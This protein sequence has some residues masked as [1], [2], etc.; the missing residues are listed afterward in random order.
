MAAAHAPSNIIDAGDV[1]VIGAGLAGLFTALKLAPRQVTV[2]AAGKRTSGAA[3]KWAQGGIA[4]AIG[5]D[6]S[7]ANHA[8]DT[9][10]AGAGLV[11]ADIATIL[12]HEAAERIA[13]LESFGVP[14]DRDADGQ[15]RLGREAAHSHNRIIGV[16]GDRAGREIMQALMAQAE[17][18]PSLNFIEGFAAYEL[19]VEN[20]RVV[21]VFARPASSTTLT[22]PL[23]I[24]AK[25]TILATGGSGHL[26]AVTT[27]PRFANGEA[28]A[29]A[30][31]A[32]AQISDAEFVQFHP[33]ALT[34]QGDPAPLATEALRGEGAVLVNRHG[35]RFMADVHPDAEL[36]PRDIVAR[37]VFNEIQASGGVGLDL[38]PSGLAA[39]LDTRFPTVAASCK[40]AGID[41]TQTAL[42]IAPATHFHMGGIRTDTNGRTS[43]PGLWACGEVAATGAHGANRLASN[44]LLEAIVFGARIAHDINHSVTPGSPRA[45]LPPTTHIDDEIVEAGRLVKDL[46]QLMSRHVGVVRDHA[47]LVTALHGLKRL[48][49]AAAGAAPY[50][51]MILAAQFITVGALARCESRGGHYRADH[52]QTDDTAHHSRLTLSDI[53][54][55]YAGLPERDQ[56]LPLSAH[57]PTRLS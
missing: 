2:L 55:A 24:R 42:P 16:S 47:G 53:E 4:A 17:A 41:P 5:P 46:R 19:A 14:F 40:K 28:L 43:L 33:T 25:A 27:N 20:G 48:Q 32:G 52:T 35:H 15:M 56:P 22:A 57:Q 3:S 36:A 26:F 49:N 7:P 54:A 31:R 6:D 38:R 11:D 37:A 1:L 50:A 45:P 51:N 18:T 10:A 9:I 30:A 21:G 29:M 34:G 8:R 44:S 23:F 12:A 39:A 13:D